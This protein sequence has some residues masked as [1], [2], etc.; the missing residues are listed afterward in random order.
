MK[1]ISNRVFGITMFLIVAIGMTF[2]IFNNRELSNYDLIFFSALFFLISFF[3]HLILHEAGHLVGGLLSGYKFVSFRVGPLTLVKESSGRYKIKLYNVPGTGGQCL[4]APPE[5]SKTDYPYKLYYWGGVIINLL[6]SLIGILLSINSMG[7]LR[8][9]ANMLT[10]VGIVVTA[11]NGIPLVGQHSDGTNILDMNNSMDARLATYNALEMNRLLTEGYRPREIPDDVISSDIYRDKN[12]PLVVTLGANYYLK[13]MDQGDYLGT[14][15]NLRKTMHN[16]NTSDLIKLLLEFEYGTMAML[17]GNYDIPKESMQDKQFIKYSKYDKLKEILRFNYIYNLLVLKDEAAANKYLK[18]LEKLTKHDPFSGEVEMNCDLIRAA[19]DIA[20]RES[21]IIRLSEVDSTNN[22]TKEL[23]ISELPN[24]Y[25]IISEIQ[26]AGRGQ[27]DKTFFS[28]SGGIYMSIILKPKLSLE[29]SKY[30]SAF[31]GIQVHDAISDVLKKNVKIKW[32]NDIIYKD[33]KVGGILTE[34]KLNYENTLDYAIVGI[35]LNLYSTSPVPE[36]INKVYG[37]LEVAD[38]K[39]LKR[40][41]EYEIIDRVKTLAVKQNIPEMIKR[42]NELLYKKNEVI[43]LLF[44]DVEVEGILIG[45]SEDLDI[46]VDIDGGQKK[47]SYNEAKL[48]LF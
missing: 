7:Y 44:D 27:R 17:L 38:Y 23:N 48:S 35:G 1:K 40:S 2:I 47:Y 11:T 19:Q 37:T 8:L 10:F 22:Y 9:F 24:G 15:R 41:L 14:V 29:E 46:L 28:P 12:N 21:E 13:L 3:M 34:T 6:L 45:V 43:K 30:L 4:L 32:I 33:K 42:Y 5:G 18:R 31:T 20:R 26:S 16:P 25:T 36:D 39:L